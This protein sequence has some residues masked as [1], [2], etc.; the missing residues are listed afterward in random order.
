MHDDATIVADAKRTCHRALLGKYAS[1][2]AASSDFALST[3]DAMSDMG[4]VS[5]CSLAAAGAPTAPSPA[6][7]VAMST[8]ALLAAVATSVGQEPTGHV[9]STCAVHEVQDGTQ[10]PEAAKEGGFGSPVVDPAEEHH[11]MEDDSTIDLYQQIIRRRSSPKPQRV[12]LGAQ[13]AQPPKPSPSTPA[14][15]AVVAEVCGC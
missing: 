12:L 11:V 2:D 3:Q 10:P 14:A 8:P 15:R 4:N 1:S 13:P 6:V 9:E 5:G 7:A